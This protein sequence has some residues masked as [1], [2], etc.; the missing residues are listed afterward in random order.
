MAND[1]KISIAYSKETGLDLNI[2][3]PPEILIRM[4]MK[5]AKNN[6]FNNTKK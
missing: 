1:V 3:I 5:S 2:E 6:L 4:L